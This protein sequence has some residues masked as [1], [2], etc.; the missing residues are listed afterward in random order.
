M[1]GAQAVLKAPVP[2]SLL[3]NTVSQK[4]SFVAWCTEQSCHSTTRI[5][6]RRRER[7]KRGILK[8]AESLLKDTFAGIL[9]LLQETNGR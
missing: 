6:G 3:P 9:K 2:V 5:P 1:T 8:G 7:A 4:G